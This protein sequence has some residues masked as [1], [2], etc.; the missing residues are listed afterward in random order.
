M[1]GHGWHIVARMRIGC[2]ARLGI[3]RRG[4]GR[5]GRRYYR[6]ARRSVWLPTGS[7]SFTR[8]VRVGLSS[9]KGSVVSFAFA[10]TC[11]LGRRGRIQWQGFS[12]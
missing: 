1:V 4:S 2:V 9:G 8:P 5:R 6:S 10:S 11:A 12:F 3:H 7:R